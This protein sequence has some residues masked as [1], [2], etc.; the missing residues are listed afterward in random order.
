MNVSPFFV[1]DYS[2]KQR[3]ERHFSLLIFRHFSETSKLPDLIP[4]LP[5]SGTQTWQGES[6]FFLFLFLFFYYF[7]QVTAPQDAHGPPMYVYLGRHNVI[8]M[9]KWTRPFPSVFAYC[10]Y[11]M[12]G[13]PGNEARVTTLWL[14]FCSE[15]AMQ[16]P[17]CSTNHRDNTNL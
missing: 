7:K 2:Q 17:V 4:R 11:W 12:V 1:F 15:L 9:I 14:N 5:H 6:V 13:R 8:H 10:K 3:K 16:P